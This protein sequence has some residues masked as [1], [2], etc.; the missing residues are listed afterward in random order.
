M[1][2]FI[3]NGQGQVRVTLNQSLNQKNHGGYRPRLI[4]SGGGGGINY[5]A[6]LGGVPYAT[7][8]CTFPQYM[9]TKDCIYNPNTNVTWFGY[10]SG[11][12]SAR[13]ES[14]MTFNHTTQAWT[15]PIVVSSDPITDDSH[16]NISF[17]FDPQGYVWGFYGSHVS[18]DQPY[19]VSVNPND[20]ASWSSQQTLPHDS[21]GYSYPQ[22]S[23]HGSTAFIFYRSGLSFG[24]YI[25]S[26]TLSSGTATWNSKVTFVD[27]S[28]AGQG[29]VYQSVHR[30]HSVTGEEHFVTGYV[31]QATS[32]YFDVFYFIFD[33]VT[34][35]F[36]NIDSSVTRNTASL[37][38]TLSEAQANF[39]I[40][41]T[42]VQANSVM[43]PDMILDIN[44]NPHVFWFDNSGGATPGYFYHRTYTNGIASS[45]TA[46]AAVPDHALACTGSILST[47]GIQAIWTVDSLVS[48]G[49]GN[50]EGNFGSGGYFLYRNT[51]TLAGGWGTAQLLQVMP[52][53][54]PFM[55]VKAIVNGLPQARMAWMECLQSDI[56]DGRTGSGTLRLWAWGETS[57]LDG[58][59]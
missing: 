58:P 46:L 10:E 55:E 30:I 35:N 59:V 12:S 56:N 23:L 52:R 15:G 33:P 48:P 32:Q 40:V 54:F 26:A 19:R 9:F 45:D 29:R 42:A 13:S 1:K 20:P 38:I 36:R 3:E 41:T 57:F 27:F 18:T 21:N 49:F 50:P 16:G 44:N 31:N 14:V 11:L 24:T 34:G 43:I 28:N 17:G 22:W 39:R 51:W 25:K 8:G 47:G 53:G 5:N 2:E 6:A 4:G 7:N 37:P